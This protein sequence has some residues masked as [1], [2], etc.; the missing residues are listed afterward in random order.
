MAKPKYPVYSD[1][2]RKR[3]GYN[4]DGTKR[5]E[6]RGKHKDYSKHRIVYNPN[7]SKPYVYDGLGNY[8]GTYYDY[9]MKHPGKYTQIMTTKMKLSLTKKQ[10]AYLVECDKEGEKHGYKPKKK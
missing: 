3:K 5:K 9:R 1:G 7:S 8:L 10:I 6:R 2:T 4:R